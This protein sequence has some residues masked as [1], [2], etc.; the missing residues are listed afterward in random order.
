MIGHVAILDIGSTKVA[1]LIAEVHSGGTTTAVGFG[2]E[3]CAGIRKGAVVDMDDTVRAIRAAVEKAEASCDVRVEAVSVGVTGDHIRFVPGEGQAMVG[4][5]ARAITASDVQRAVENSRSVPL[6]HD[7]EVLDVIPWSYRVD[8]RDGFSHP[9]GIVGS[10]LAVRSHVIV[11][12]SA[13]VRT[14]AEAVERAD[15]E[16]TE[17][18]LEPLATGRAALTDTEC[19]VGT[20]LLDIGGNSTNVA[21]FRDNV[22]HGFGLVPVGSWHVTSD[23]SKLLRTSMEEAEWLK[24]EFGSTRHTEISEEE[25]V[26]VRQIGSPT[27]RMLRRKLLAEIIHPRMLE[28]F[29]MARSVVE[30]F[31]HKRLLPGG[32]VLAGGGSKLDGVQALATAVMDG[33]PVRMAGV[34]DG[35][36]CIPSNDPEWMTPM[37]L[38]Q[39]AAEGMRNEHDSQQAGDWL[40]NI[41][42]RL[43]EKGT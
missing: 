39:C 15:L 3:A 23:V 1:C 41:R 13:P 24:V 26:E 16:L 8:G 6:A 40:S 12:G 18:I 37:G 34:E 21:L 33:M 5:A 2:T 11:G 43:F 10:R 4:G 29:T 36:P 25:L 32:V 22:I 31:G 35:G 42:R 7:E 30:R 17:L 27:P 9:V 14:L 20:V 28:L 19:Q 38:L